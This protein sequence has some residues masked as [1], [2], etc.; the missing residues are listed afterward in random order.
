LDED[1][2]DRYKAPALDKGLE[3]IE[4]LARADAGLTQAEIAKRIG[5][6]ASEFFRMLDRLVRRGYVN[7]DRNDRYSLTLKL[8]GLAQQHAP[9]HRLASFATPLMREFARKSSQANHLVVFDRGDAVVVAQQEAP[10]YWGVSIRVGSH[11]SLFDTGSG[12]VLLAFRSQEERELMI[13]EYGRSREEVK[14]GPEFFAHLDLIKERGHE[15]MASVQTAGIF[16]LAV[17][18]IGPDGR[19]MAALACP[20]IPL[21]DPTPA[22]DID[23]TVLLLKDTATQLSRLAGC[24]L[25]D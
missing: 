18:V 22:P 23:E 13:S 15:R 16:N 8:F 11:I 1:D 10:Q 17:P 21:L 20:Y 5:R 6:N 12:H 9:L 24:D 14:R 3:I 25:P 2:N 4:L 7:R 19:G